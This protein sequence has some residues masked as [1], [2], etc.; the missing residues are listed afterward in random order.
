MRRAVKRQPVR[1][2]SKAQGFRAKASLAVSI[3]A[4]LRAKL[5]RTKLLL[6][7]VDGVLT[8]GALL[9]GAGVEL[10]RFDIR[11]GLGLVALRQEAIKVGW[12]SSRPSTATTQRAKELKI[13]FL[14]QR[15]GSKVAAVQQ[16]LTKTGLSW[17]EVCFV[18]DD[19]VDI[20]PLRHAGVAV[21]VAD[22][23]TEAKAVADYVT[24]T[25]GGHGAVRE[26]VELILKAQDKWP[27]VI[28]NRAG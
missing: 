1:I 7:D 28:A 6:C 16:L 22:A 13:D 27:R 4:E 23:V 9:I 21:A 25:R 8:D 10:K 20:G 15:K 11:D 3:S 26:V 2:R 12:V 5:G 24:R 19:I 17:N 14:V 18:G